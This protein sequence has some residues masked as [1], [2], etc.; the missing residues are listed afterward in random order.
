MRNPFMGV[1]RKQSLLTE[2]REWKFS[3]CTG[4][5]VSMQIMQIKLCDSGLLFLAQLLRGEAGYTDS[6]DS[7]PAWCPTTS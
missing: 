2:E 1:K 5:T 3:L 7:G 4:N 6:G